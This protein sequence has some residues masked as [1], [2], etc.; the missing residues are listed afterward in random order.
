MYLF[1]VCTVG[2]AG[3]A[4]MLVC[5][6][7]AAILITH[8][9]NPSHSNHMVVALIVPLAVEQLYKYT[10]YRINISV[11][12]PCGLWAVFVARALVIDHF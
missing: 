8:I 4:L 12:L 2:P 9:V 5:L 1:V 7:G 6:S 10:N 11:E 3:L